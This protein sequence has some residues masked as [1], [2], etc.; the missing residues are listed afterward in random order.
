LEIVRKIERKRKQID[1]INRLKNSEEFP[2]WGETNSAR[3]DDHQLYVR[4]SKEVQKL[5]ERYPFERKVTNE[6]QQL[7]LRKRSNG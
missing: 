5:L 7:Q 1:L 4:Q 3:H 2:V 6:L